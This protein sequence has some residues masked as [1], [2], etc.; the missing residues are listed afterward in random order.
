[1]NREI[2]IKQWIENYNNQSYI[3]KKNVF[4]TVCNLGWFDW[5]CEDEE[6]I[7]R[8]N[9]FIPIILGL[10]IKGRVSLNKDYIFF[11]NNCPMNADLYDSMSICDIKNNDVKYWIGY[12]NDH[13]E[14][15]NNVNDITKQFDSRDEVIKYL[16]TKGD[17]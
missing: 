4:K 8:T 11:K 14:V 9:K 1:M 5:F 10:K 3:V 13:W 12:P 15:Y 7:A 16:N 17:K 2:S 6:L